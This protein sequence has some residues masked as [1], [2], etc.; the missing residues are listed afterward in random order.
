MNVFFSDT[1]KDIV[2]P[3]KEYTAVNSDIIDKAETN[4][5]CENCQR[6]VTVQRYKENEPQLPNI[7]GGRLPQ[8]H[9][10]FRTQTHCIFL[11]GHALQVFNFV[12]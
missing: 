10:T 9:H 2:R 5:H 1:W 4:T 7:R 3:F 11:Q 8:C 12:L 6:H